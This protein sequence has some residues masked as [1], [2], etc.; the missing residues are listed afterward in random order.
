MRCHE[1]SCCFQSQGKEERTCNKGKIASASAVA[2]SRDKETE[3]LITKA[4]GLPSLKGSIETRD[5][6]LRGGIL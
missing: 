5:E 6:N 1:V 4:T 3:A 2:A